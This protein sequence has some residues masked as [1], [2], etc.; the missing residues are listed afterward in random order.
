MNLASRI[1]RMPALVRDALQRTIRRFPIPLL[2]AFLGTIVALFM[3]GESETTLTRILL[4]SALAL[5][6]SIALALAGERRGGSARFVMAAAGIIVPLLYLITLP[7]IF[8]SE[9]P[10]FH[11][12][13]FWLIAAAAHLCVSF[14]P[15]LRRGERN[16]FWQFNKQLFLRMA[17]A[18]LFT[19]VITGGLIAAV[20][21]IEILF[22]VSWPQYLQFRIWITTL[23]IFNTFF[24]LA[25]VPERFDA[26]QQEKTYP[27]GLL[28]LSH[29]VMLPLTILYFVILYAYI[30]RIIIEW[31]W[32]QGTVSALIL[33]FAGF[34]I[35]TLLLAYPR[36]DN[37]SRPL[38]QS[39]VRTFYAALVPLAIVL[40]L[41]IW[42][43]VEPYGI[44]E[45][46]Y[47][48]FIGAIWMAV[49]G[50]WLAVARG[51]PIRLIP[52]TLAF[53]LVVV[54]FGPW[55]AFSVSRSS[56]Q[57]RL[58]AS[59][60]TLDLSQGTPVRIAGD[61]YYDIESTGRYLIRRHGE[62][63]VEGILEIPTS[64]PVHARVSEALA[65]L[66]ESDGIPAPAAHIFLYGH[67]EEALNITGYNRAAILDPLTDGRTSSL[68]L[69]G[70]G[71]VISIKNSGIIIE[72]GTEVETID[73][74]QV[75]A[76]P[77]SS[78]D[79]AI[80]MDRQVG[81][82]EMRFV[83]T[84]FIAGTRRHDRITALRGLVLAREL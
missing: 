72:V 19:G 46:R 68:K 22:G 70:D 21:A 62:E 67:L 78:D 84:E 50:A 6:L 75:S 15:Y 18:L 30:G 13:R 37:A 54:S 12:G 39:S 52:M 49:I 8:T 59:L 63:A 57:T 71:P 83:I 27:R 25:G 1:R 76:A 14:A 28:V 33:S 51:R 56:Q 11:F 60:D 58:A 20:S 55:G 77:R 10:T 40:F 73:A 32:P 80:V 7:R 5:P 45:S 4:T 31:S 3:V 41:A 74:K 23:G 64:A 66:I 47:L 35:L 82:W 53:L 44:T 69:S 34:G 81:N 36:Y 61:R 43:R 24:F 79:A 26:L 42:Q 29:Y 17:T 48:G 38:V 2:W 65:P 16:G 9:T